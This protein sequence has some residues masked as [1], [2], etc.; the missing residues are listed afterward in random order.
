MQK[1]YQSNYS[2]TDTQF[3][4]NFTIKPYPS[5]ALDTGLNFEK[6]T[7]SGRWSFQPKVLYQK[8]LPQN[9]KKALQNQPLDNNYE[10]NLGS[11]F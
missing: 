10:V 3:S 7:K 1:N 11:S 5:F 9:S 6:F 4:R 2:T 8:I